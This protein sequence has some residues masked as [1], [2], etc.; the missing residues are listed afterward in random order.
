MSIFDFSIF[1]HYNLYIFPDICTRYPYISPKISSGRTT[2]T[3]TP[4]SW[5]AAA[6]Y[7]PAPSSGAPWRGNVGQSSGAPW[8][9][10]EKIWDDDGTHVRKSWIW[11]K[12]AVDVRRYGLNTGINVRKSLDS[13]KDLQGIC[14]FFG[15]LEADPRM[16]S[17][18]WKKLAI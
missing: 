13:L 4:A 16:I 9:K 18:S 14:F 1:F 15:V 5:T 10:M 7:A 2:S 3:P 17:D 8:G 6:C 11:M 12:Y